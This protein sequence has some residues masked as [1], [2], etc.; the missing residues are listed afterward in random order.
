MNTNNIKQ[1][2]NIVEYINQYAPLKRAGNGEY[3]ALCPFHSE[4]SPSFTVN[5]QKQFY[6]CFG[7]GAT[8]DIIK[9][10]E[11]Y[12]GVEFID[13]CKILGGQAD[14]LDVRTLSVNRA[15]PMITYP[16]FDKRDAD[17][18]QAYIE[19]C[20]PV[21]IGE[22]NAYQYKGEWLIP[23]V[24]MDNE[25][26]VNLYNVRNGKFLLGGVSHRA[27]S[28][29]RR[30]ETNDYLIVSDFD[31]AIKLSRIKYDNILIAYSAYNMKLIVDNFDYNFIPVLTIDDTHAHSLTGTHDYLFFNGSEFI[32]KVR[33]EDY[34]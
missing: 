5:E 19:K 7:C 17:K 27:V 28:I 2:H 31:N 30:K 25:Q 13:A 1:S 22:V 32:E 21:V 11:Q 12:Q 34:E 6:Y 10:V 3:S 4:K 29:I 18:T 33:G 20:E 15:R 14:E 24:D 23:I 8:G 16:K 9:F 26:I